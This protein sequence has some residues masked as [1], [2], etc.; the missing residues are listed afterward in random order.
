MNWEWENVFFFF[1]SGAE[2]GIEKI[3]FHYVVRLLVTGIITTLISFPQ[4]MGNLLCPDDLVDIS[5]SLHFVGALP[6]YFLGWRQPY[7]FPFINGQIPSAPF[8]VV[9]VV[10]FTLVSAPCLLCIGKHDSR[11]TC[12]AAGEIRTR[13][14]TFF[15]WFF[16]FFFSFSWITTVFVCLQH[17]ADKCRCMKPIY[18][19]RSFTWFNSRIRHPLY[20]LFSWF[21]LRSSKLNRDNTPYPRTPVEWVTYCWKATTTTFDK[22][23]IWSK[24]HPI[25]F[26]LS[27]SRLN[28]RSYRSISNRIWTVYETISFFL[29]GERVG[30]GERGGNMWWIY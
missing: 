21:L 11:S 2:S 3:I 28:E 20:T 18:S 24:C 15:F 8:V 10:V 25:F 23:Q 12:M 26:F 29:V 9:V 4:F 19:C 16:F 1:A 22:S 27:L 30:T 6:F 17:S 7:I 13:C 14:A 5:R